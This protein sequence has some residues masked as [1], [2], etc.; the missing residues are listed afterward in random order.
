[1]QH[2]QHHQQP[3]HPQH[4]QPQHQ[5]QP[6]HSGHA[7][8]PRPGQQWQGEPGRPA[9]PPATQRSHSQRPCRYF[10]TPK[11]RL[12]VS[13]KDT[14]AACTNDVDMDSERIETPCCNHAFVN[15]KSSCSQMFAGL[16][17]GGSLQLCAHSAA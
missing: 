12:L 16:L 4:Q 1:L 6:S 5:H 10:N 15:R 17:Y 3:Q 2:H 14:G 8:M 9:R 13:C 11:V 7:G